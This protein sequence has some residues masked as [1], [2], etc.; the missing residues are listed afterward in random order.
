MPLTVE[1][2]RLA[3]AARRMLDDDQFQ[4]VLDNVVAAAAGHALFL[5]QPDAREQARQMVIAVSRIRN[6]LQAAA[7]LPED[8]RTADVLARSME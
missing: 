1:Q 2:I 8:D 3:R 5:D 4:A 7:E 6:E